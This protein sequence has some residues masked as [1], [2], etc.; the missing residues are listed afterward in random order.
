MEDRPAVMT[1]LHINAS[2]QMGI[3]LTELNKLSPLQVLY[4]AT[5]PSFVSLPMGYG[6]ISSG[7]VV[8][9]QGL[10]SSEILLQRYTLDH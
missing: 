7:F 6:N 5:I 9:Y 4:R 2:Q 8:P 1:A 3:E 10:L